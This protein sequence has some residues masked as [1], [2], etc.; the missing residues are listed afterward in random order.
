MICAWWKESVGKSDLH[1]ILRPLTEIPTV[2]DST[3]VEVI[4]KLETQQL[5]RITVLPAGA[6]VG[7]LTG[8]TLCDQ[9]RKVNM[10]LGR[11]QARQRRRQLSTRFAALVC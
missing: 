2:A 7:C 8:A 10:P 5:P 4:N 6:V 11:N 9:L 3:L 1:S